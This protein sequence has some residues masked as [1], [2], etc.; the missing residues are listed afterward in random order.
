MLVIWM[1]Y[2]AFWLSFDTYSPIQCQQ[3]CCRM[4]IAV[5]VIRLKS[6]LKSLFQL[7]DIL[8]YDTVSSGTGSLRAAFQRLQMNLLANPTSAL[9]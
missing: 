6:S 4:N 5:Q 3:R 9:L 1:R 7:W 2:E 8:A